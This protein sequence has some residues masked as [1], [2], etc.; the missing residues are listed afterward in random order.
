MVQTKSVSIELL[1]RAM[2]TIRGLKIEPGSKRS[3]I[4]G[5]LILFKEAEL[6]AVSVVMAKMAPLL[7]SITVIDPESAE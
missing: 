2:A 5:F 3:E 1:S 6:V 4:A 7:E